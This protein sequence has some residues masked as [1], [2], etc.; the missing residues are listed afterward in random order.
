M[1]NGLC[2]YSFGTIP[3]IKTIEQ[4]FNRN[5]PVCVFN[6]IPVQDL[7]S[8]ACGHHCIYLAAHKCISFD[9]NA[10]INMYINDKSFN[11]DLVKLFIYKKL[12]QQ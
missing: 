6:S 12:M 11:D 9:M 4:F 8:N 10:I 5:V 2:F 1:T 3:A 7:L